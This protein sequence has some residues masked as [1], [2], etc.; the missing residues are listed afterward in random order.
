MEFLDILNGVLPELPLLREI[1]HII[2]LMDEGKQYY[3]S[4]LKNCPNIW[5]F[6][7]D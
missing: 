4:G 7:K 3:Y 2:P 1:N 5:P 6:W